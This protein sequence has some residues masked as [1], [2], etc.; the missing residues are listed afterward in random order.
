MSLLLFGCVVFGCLAPNIV[1]LSKTRPT[2]NVAHILWYECEC[3]LRKMIRWALNFKRDIR[4]SLLFLAANAPTL[5]VLMLKRLTRFF[6]SA[7]A[8]PRFITRVINQMRDTDT[9]HEYGV[10]SIR[11]Y[12]N[13]RE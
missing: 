1:S 13:L 10:N 4:C 7:T 6:Q 9:H 8:H 3:H 11:Y 5:Q 2:R 12:Y